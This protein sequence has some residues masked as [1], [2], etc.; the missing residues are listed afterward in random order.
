MAMKTFYAK[1]WPQF[2]TQNVCHSHLFENHKDV[3]NL[4]IMQLASSNLHKRYVARKA[5]LYLSLAYFQ[6]RKAF[7]SHGINVK[8]CHPIRKALYLSLTIAAKGLECENNL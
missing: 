3:L 1:F 8:W 2:K 5:I 4:E 6:K 7:I